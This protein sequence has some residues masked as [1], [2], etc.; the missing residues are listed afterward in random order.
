MC[1]RCVSFFLIADWY[2]KEIFKPLSIHML[3]LLANVTCEP[4]YRR[5]LSRKLGMS[6]WP[7]KKDF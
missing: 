3:F 6:S 5:L 2:Q 1:L 4:L 7:T